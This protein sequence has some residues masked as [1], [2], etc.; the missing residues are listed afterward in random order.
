MNRWS[1]HSMGGNSLGVGIDWECLKDGL[2][3]EGSVE[4]EEE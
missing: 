4:E 3:V 2:E 1:G